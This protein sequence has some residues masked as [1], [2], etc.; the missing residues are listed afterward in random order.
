V[1]DSDLSFSPLHLHKRVSVVDYLLPISLNI[2]CFVDGL[3]LFE[4]F[5]LK[6]GLA[7]SALEYFGS[8]LSFSG[9]EDSLMLAGVPRALHFFSRL[10]E[11]TDSPLSLPAPFFSR[12]SG[13]RP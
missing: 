5:F 13:E 6:R 8:F 3:L 10:W 7:I 4:V 9:A 12:R 2:H 1:I 11:D